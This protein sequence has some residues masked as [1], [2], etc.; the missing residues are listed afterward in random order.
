MN[1]ETI[2]VTGGAGFIGSNI[3]IDLLERNDSVICVDNFDDYY[4]PQ[5]KE[6]NIKEF[7]KYKNFNLF[8]SDVRD[9]NTMKI[10]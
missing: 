10:T 7:K 9:Y 5:I 3:I 8:R 6:Q 4:N 2:M 1:D